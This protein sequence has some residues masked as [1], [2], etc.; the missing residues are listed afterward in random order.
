MDAIIRIKIKSAIFIKF[1]HWGGLG[2][3]VIRVN[4]GSRQ[5]STRL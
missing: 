1:N 3:E 4:F 5:C 2:M